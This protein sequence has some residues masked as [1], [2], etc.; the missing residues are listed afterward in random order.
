MSHATATFTLND[1]NVYYGEF[2]GTSGYIKVGVFITP[3]E[4][5]SQWRKDHGKGC[6]CDD[7]QQLVECEVDVDYGSGYNWEG[8]LCTRCMKFLGRFEPFE[9]HD[10]WSEY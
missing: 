1:G 5:D 3:E 2:D 6:A 9:S 4:R 8:K 7:K 10:P